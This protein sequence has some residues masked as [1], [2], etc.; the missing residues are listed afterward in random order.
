MVMTMTMM[1]VTTLIVEAPHDGIR[2]PGAASFLL[3]VQLQHRRR[4][5]V[6]E[7]LSCVLQ[8]APS[9]VAEAGSGVHEGVD[10]VRPLF[11]AGVGAL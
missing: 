8:N 1:M 11:R 6:F 3:C 2:Q 9:L 4:N 10:V 7:A 5:D